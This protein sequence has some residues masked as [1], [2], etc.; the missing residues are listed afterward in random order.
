L[1]CPECESGQA[2]LKI[3]GKAAAGCVVKV[4]M[5]G[6]TKEF[7]CEECASLGLE[8]GVGLERDC[9][10]KLCPLGTFGGDVA[11]QT[12]GIGFEHPFFG[13]FEVFCKAG[14][15][16]SCLT[17]PC[18]GKSGCEIDGNVQCGAKV[19]GLL[20]KVLVGLGIEVG[21]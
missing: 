16:A 18:A 10:G 11:V 17:S 13:G 15:E 12:P 14:V 3:P 1:A 21:L 4:R 7:G 8:V 2:F 6:K 20:K 9:Q 19:S 5:F